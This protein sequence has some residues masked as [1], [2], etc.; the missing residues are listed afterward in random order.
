MGRVVLPPCCLLGLR[1]SSPGVHRL[2]GRAKGY[3][4]KDLGRHPPPGLLL[5]NAPIPMQAA[6]NPQ[7][8]SQGGRPQ[9]LVGSLL[10]SLDPGVHKDLFVPSKSL[11]FPHS[12]EVLYQIPLSFKV[13]FTGDSQPLCR[14]TRLRSLTWG[15]ELCSSVKTSLELLI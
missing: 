6:A 3:L 4:Q 10:S 1:R 14:I 2:D 13:R 7:L 5:A 15:L 8:F 12:V 9:S 11:C